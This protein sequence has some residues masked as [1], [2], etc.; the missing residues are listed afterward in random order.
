M[1]SEA[2]AGLLATPADTLNVHSHLRFLLGAQ[3]LQPHESEGQWPSPAARRCH[4]RTPL[5]R[6]RTCAPWAASWAHCYELTY[7][8]S[9]L[10]AEQFELK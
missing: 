10:S 7:V 8:E 1:S 9:N 3:G 6:L 5:G 2:R 4:H